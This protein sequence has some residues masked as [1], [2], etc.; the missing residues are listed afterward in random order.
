MRKS[1]VIKRVCLDLEQVF[2]VWSLLFC[3]VRM[4]LFDSAN[5]VQINNSHYKHICNF[6]VEEA[7]RNVGK[8]YKLTDLEQ[9]SI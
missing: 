5:P 6:S 2:D 4:E 3:A 9:S 1:S 8:E 7:I